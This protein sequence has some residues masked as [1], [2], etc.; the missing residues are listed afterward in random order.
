MIVKK[1]LRT[2]LVCIVIILA[3]CADEGAVPER[4]VAWTNLLA[5]S[6]SGIL[7]GSW[8]QAESEWSKLKK[9]NWSN[10]ELR[11]WME[12]QVEILDKTKND[13]LKES[14][15]LVAIQEMYFYPQAARLHL[16]WLKKGLQDG[17]FK[18]KVRRKAQETVDAI[19]SSKSL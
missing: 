13:P 18:M 17:M 9:P 11:L 5:S 19:E 4:Q 14:L 8:Y 10:E 15:R 2:S 6:R 12:L 3:S 7:T 1:I 16:E